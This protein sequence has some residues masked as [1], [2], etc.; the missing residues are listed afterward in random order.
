[1]GL[2]REEDEPAR[3]RGWPRDPTRAETRA[4]DCSPKRVFPFGFRLG[5]SSLASYK[6]YKKRMIGKI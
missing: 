4:G 2:S 6:G 1:L 3:P 5:F